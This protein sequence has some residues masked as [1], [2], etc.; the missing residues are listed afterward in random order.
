MRLQVA[1]VHMQVGESLY[2]H[3]EQKVFGLKK[4]FDQVIDVDVNFSKQSHEHMADISMHAGGIH[5]H[6]QGVADDHYTAVDNAVQKLARQLEK[7]KGRMKKHRSRRQND[8][9]ALPAFSVI[10]ATHHKVEEASLEEA[11]ED[12]FAEYMPRIVHKD[13]RKVQVLTVDEAVMQMDLL[14]TS[15]FIFQNHKTGDL[16]VVYRE[17]NGTVGW[18]EPK[19]SDISAAKAS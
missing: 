15:F 16:N 2:N 9:T 12:L 14:H 7:Y 13:V 3:C 10:E 1:G 4:Y 6:A 18:V 5:L 17:A 8:D 19:K 11:P